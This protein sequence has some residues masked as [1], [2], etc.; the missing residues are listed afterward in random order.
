[1]RRQ[2]PSDTPPQEVA[3]PVPAFQQAVDERM[4]ARNAEL[5]AALDEVRT[6]KAQLSAELAALRRRND[7]R[8]RSPTRNGAA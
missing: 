8:S 2:V 5:K 3:Q 1:M 4:D 7:G 6:L